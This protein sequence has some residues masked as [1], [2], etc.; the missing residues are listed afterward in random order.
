M[1][2]TIMPRLSRQ[3]RAEALREAAREAE[4]RQMAQAL[5]SIAEHVRAMRQRLDALPPRPEHP[6]EPGPL[7]MPA[8]DEEWEVMRRVIENKTRKVEAVIAMLNRKA[9][10]S[11]RVIQIAHMR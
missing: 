7:P 6:G 3:V 11:R 4:L 10:A 9:E 5:D 2:P 8:T 1:Q